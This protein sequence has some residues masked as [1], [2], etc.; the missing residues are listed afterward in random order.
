M[1]EQNIYFYFY[2]LLYINEMVIFAGQERVKSFTNIAILPWKYN[3]YLFRLDTDE[4]P[5]K[6]ETLCQAE[7]VT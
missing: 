2:N 1:C 4:N 3:Y 7:R 6:L 5:F